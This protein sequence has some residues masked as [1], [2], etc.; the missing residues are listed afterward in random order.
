MDSL[1]EKLNK[2]RNPQERIVLEC[3]ELQ[4]NVIVERACYWVE[5]LLQII[6]EENWFCF[7]NSDP[8]AI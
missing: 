6:A 7:R 2:T 5:R 4:E 1:T 8:V 3:C